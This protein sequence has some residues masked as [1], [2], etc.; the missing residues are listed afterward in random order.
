MHLPH[1]LP[2]RSK[3]YGNKD[4]SNKTSILFTLNVAYTL[5]QKDL[6]P[7]KSKN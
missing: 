2:N 1:L 7:D 5:S 4:S 3:C 6:F